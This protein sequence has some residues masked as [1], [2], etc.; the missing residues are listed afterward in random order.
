MLKNFYEANLEPLQNAGRL[1]PLSSSSDSDTPIRITSRT[2]LGLEANFGSHFSWASPW[3]DGEAIL[4]IPGAHNLQNALGAIALCLSTGL[5]NTSHVKK[6]LSNPKLSPL[7][8]ELSRLANGAILFN[9]CYNAN[10]LSSSSA[11]KATKLI[12]ANSA[13]GI[14]RVIV[15]MGDMLELGEFTAELHEETAEVAARCDVDLLLSTGDFS[16]QWTK[17]FL[18]TA[19][20]GQSA[21]SFA[22][23]PQ[24]IERLE[25]E[26]A[27]DPEHTLVLVKGSRG[28]AMKEIVFKLKGSNA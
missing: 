7:R 23:K 13:A 19:K 18:K 26:I 28:S 27:E 21:E 22:G 1:Y 5:C 20:A 9:D 3:G 8:S 24:L 12:R 10:P 6:A 11:F 17:G 4:P 14:S 25:R 16:E 2:D 15:C